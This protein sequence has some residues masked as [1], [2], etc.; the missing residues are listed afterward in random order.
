M[1][2]ASPP[3]I[4]APADD[5]AVIEV[6]ASRPDQA[7]KIDRR[8]YRMKDNPHAAQSDTLQLLRGLPAVVVTPD[9]QLL[10]LGSAGVTILVDE[11]PVPGDVTQYLRTLHGNDIERIEIITNPSAQYAAQGSGGIINLVL[12]R[13]RADGVSGSAS[14][15]ASSLGRGE[16]SA[17]IKKKRGKWTYSLRADATVGRFATSTFRKLRTV[18]EP[19]GTTSINSAAGGGSSGVATANVALR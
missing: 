17:T 18:E 1:Q 10:L 7:Q 13:K 11:R 4:V 15:L 5:S 19:D 9:D 12:R 14:L 16:A 6:V 8:I 2:A 3:A